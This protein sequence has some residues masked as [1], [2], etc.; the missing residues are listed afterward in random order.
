MSVGGVDEPDEHPDKF[1]ERSSYEKRPACFNGLWYVL[2]SPP[3]LPSLHTPPPLPQVDEAL[4]PPPPPSPSCPTRWMQGNPASDDVAS[5]FGSKW[6]NMVKRGTG[7]G[8]PKTFKK[9]HSKDEAKG[10]PTEV[11]GAGSDTVL[12]YV[13]QVRVA[14]PNVWTWHKDWKGQAGFKAVRVEKEEGSE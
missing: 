6:Q 2:C 11:D 3:S 4:T 13:M 1:H 10:A 9:E 5:F 14:N 7:H 8:W 12:K